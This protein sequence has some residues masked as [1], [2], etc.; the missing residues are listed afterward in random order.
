MCSD[1]DNTSLPS[2]RR[3]CTKVLWCSND[4]MLSY[5]YA[6]I[7]SYSSVK[8]LR[9][10]ATDF[11]CPI[12]WFLIYYIHFYI[13]AM[14]INAPNLLDEAQQLFQDKKTQFSC[15]A[16][17]AL[18][19][20]SIIGVA[21]FQIAPA[22]ILFLSVFLLIAVLT[23]KLHW[24]IYL[25]TASALFQEWEINFGSYDFSH[26]LPMLANINA[27]LTDF[28]AVF[29]LIAFG[30]ALLLKL[31]HI[32]KSR[33]RTVLPL[34]ISFGI[35]L[36]IAYIATHFAYNGLYAESISFWLRPMAYI[37]VVYIALPLI[38]VRQERIL[39]HMMYILFGIGIL[40]FIYGFI[41][42]FISP[43]NSW[44]RVHPFPLWQGFAPL[45][46]N[47]NLIAEPL[48]III[49]IGV[50]LWY[51][52]K[53]AWIGLLT[54]GMLCIA[55]LTLSR[56]AWVSVGCASIVA[57]YVYRDAVRAWVSERKMAVT[58]IVLVFVVPFVAYMGYF[59][60]TSSVVKSSNESR[61]EMS[62]I[63]LSYAKERP[64]LGYGPGTYLYLLGDTY[65]Y[66]MEFGDPLESHGVLQKIA[67]EEGIIGLMA[68]G[69]FM[70]I[71]IRMLLHLI[72]YMHGDERHIVSV[73]LIMV[74]ASFI[75]QLF[76]TS[77]FKGVL[78]LPI[79]MSIVVLS[80]SISRY[81]YKAD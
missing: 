16:I 78:W 73:L 22:A 24:G 18:F 76:N 31:V 43:D 27:P 6:L 3:D 19:L 52:S 77:Y 29:T 55:L 9:R 70:Y 74:S 63:A 61:I 79:G 14:H 12:V 65:V 67:V 69:V 54:F 68:F 51:M 40:I 50:Y 47:H 13:Y 1:V 58:L 46:I 15:G 42:L 66:R 5:F 62:R 53:R 23:F 21:L 80:L 32:E 49:P 25:I 34:L 38:V 64:I 8:L 4:P 44:T 41:S 28:F 39:R 7:L 75:F 17:L 72:S 33:I 71:L 59:L 36:F 2:S 57:L 26:D 56:A 30:I 20:F 81:G 60:M 35:F 48:M 11:G 10:Q 37:G 45:G